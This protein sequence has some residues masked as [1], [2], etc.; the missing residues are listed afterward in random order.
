MWGLPAASSV[1]CS[2]A[3]RA[4]PAAG[5]NV[6]LTRQF[7]FGASTAPQSF[8]CTKSP[9]FIPPSAMPPRLSA[10]LP[11]LANTTSCSALAWLTGVP[12]NTN[13]AGDTTAD[14]LTPVPLRLRV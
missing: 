10:P 6:T 11:L 1:N 12:A 7:V 13:D 3:V 9:A 8:T 14:G 5:A 4:P 2:V